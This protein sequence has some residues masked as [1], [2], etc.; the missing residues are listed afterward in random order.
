M[1][2]KTLLRLRNLRI[3]LTSVLEKIQT[4]QVLDFH[5]VA[6]SFKNLALVY[7][8]K[9]RIATISKTKRHVFSLI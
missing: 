9:N 2:F 5:T 4:L 1:A 8:D 7:Q 3:N 6:S